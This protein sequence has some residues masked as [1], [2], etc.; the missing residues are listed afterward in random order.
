MNKETLPLVNLIA[1]AIYDKK[2]MNILAIDVS[3]VGSTAD[4]V[5]VA[6]GTVDR[7]V[8]AIAREVEGVMDSSGNPPIYTEGRSHGDWVVL[9]FGMIAVHLFMPEMRRK[10][11]LERLWADGKLLELDLGSKVS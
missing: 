9:D 7:H 5:V 4:I 2:G 11:Q 3:E 8:I 6:E 1:K 10:Y